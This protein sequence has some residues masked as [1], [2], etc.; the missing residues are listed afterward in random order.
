[1]IQN[2]PCTRA[3]YFQGALALSEVL[4]EHEE[5]RDQYCGLIDGAVEAVEA[6]QHHLKNSQP[7]I[8]RITA[9]LKSRWGYTHFA[10]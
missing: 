10:V 2:L 7:E 3:D 5:Y 9:V 1:M 4:L 8:G 6:T